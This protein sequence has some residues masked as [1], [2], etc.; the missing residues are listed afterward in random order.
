VPSTKAAFRY[1]AAASIL[2]FLSFLVLLSCASHPAG[3][4]RESFASVEAVEPQWRPLAS[5]VDFFHGKIAKPRL[6]TWA[7]RIDLASPHTRILV[8]GGASHDGETILSTRVSSFVKDNGLI[9]G[10]NAVP[11]DVV[12]AEEGRPIT[13]AGI[14]ISSGRL[15]SPPNPRF[16]AL[17][18]YKDGRL[19]IVRQEAIDNIEEI[20]CAVGGF[21]RILGAGETEERAK[22]MRERHPR[23]AAG[24]SA[25]G[26][27]L[28]FLVIDGR[29][30]SSIGATEEETAILL[31]ALGS[32]DGLNFD[33][34]GSSALALRQEDGAV[35]I[36]NTPIHNGIPGMERAVAGC[37]GVRKNLPRSY[38]EK[39]R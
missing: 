12:S 17:A 10:I 5:G 30:A 39:E 23:S 22:R 16:D 24:V 11:F 31:R 1:S 36:V 21:Y 38:T 28:Y 14:V 37:I 15:V 25:D 9:T 4:V 35:R 20:D 19:A 6:E 3:A 26:R 18:L 27:R 34:G 29:R 13:N 32:W 7:V 33:G 2:A 8:M